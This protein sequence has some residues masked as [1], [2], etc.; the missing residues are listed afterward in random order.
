MEYGMCLIKY[1]N[2]LQEEHMPEDNIT[3]KDDGTGIDNKN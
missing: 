1:R 2:M 3:S